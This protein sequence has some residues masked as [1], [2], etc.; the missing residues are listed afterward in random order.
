[1]REEFMEGKL[2]ELRHKYKKNYDIK[3]RKLEKEKYIKASVNMRKK[4]FSSY[5]MQFEKNNG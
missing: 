5:L 2:V 3:F 4:K 1:M